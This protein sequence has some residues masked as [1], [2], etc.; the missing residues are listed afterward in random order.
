MLPEMSV[1]VVNLTEKLKQRALALSRDKET[2]LYNLALFP[3][4]Q[5]SDTL[6][7]VLAMRMTQLHEQNPL[8]IHLINTYGETEGLIGS[9][10]V[11]T[12]L[13]IAT[14]TI[15]SRDPKD[16]YRYLRPTLF[17][18]AGNLLTAAAVIHNFGE[19]YFK[20]N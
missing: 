7:T 5:S 3:L 17:L 12:L 11:G 20:L 16:E 13:A 8:I 19:I 2:Y 6:S 15:I 18:R 14:A 1:C 4:I 10:I 9:K